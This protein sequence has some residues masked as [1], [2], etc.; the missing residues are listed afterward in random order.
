MTR[1]IIRKTSSNHVELIGTDPFDG[2]AIHWTFS[3]PYGGGYVRHAQSRAQVCG[4][5]GSTGGTLYALSEDHL[6]P[7]IRRK[8]QARRK[9]AAKLM[10]R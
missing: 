9:D 3:C 7:L 6:L 10:A 2:S 4:A 8:W 1:T 5:L